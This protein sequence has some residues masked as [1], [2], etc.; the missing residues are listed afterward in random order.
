MFVELFNAGANARSYEPVFLHLVF[1]IVLALSVIFFV[2]NLVVNDGST[3]RSDGHTWWTVSDITTLISAGLVVVQWAAG[4]WTIMTGWRCAFMLLD[5]PGMRVKDLGHV[6]SSSFLVLFDWCL[7]WKP[8][9]SGWKVFTI[10]LLW[11]LI[12]ASVSGPLISGAV[13]WQSTFTWVDGGFVTPSYGGP[14]A[15]TDWYWYLEPMWQLNNDIPDHRPTS[16]A[17]GLAG[18]A[19]STKQQP[20]VGRC[21]RVMPDSSIPPNSTVANATIPCIEIHDISFNSNPSPDI[22]NVLNS[23][24]ENVSLFQN[25]VV[26]PLF[27]YNFGNAILFDSSRWNESYL[28]SGGGT[29]QLPPPTI[30]SGLKTFIVF[31]ARQNAPNCK[32]ING[33]AFGD[34]ATLALLEP[35]LYV[36]QP[37]TS[38]TT[39]CMLIGSVNFTAGVVQSPKSVYVSNRVVETTET[40][41]IEPAMFVKDALL[42]MPDVM[43][44]V[45]QVNTSG[46][47]TWDNVANYTDTLIRYSYMA[48][49][50]SLNSY[51]GPE[52]PD[53]AV[54]KAVPML[55]ASVSRLRVYLWLL[56]N[57]F[58]TVTAIMTVIAYMND[59]IKRMVVDYAAVAMAAKIK[60]VPKGPSQ[61]SQLTSLEAGKSEGSKIT[62]AEVEKDLKILEFVEEEIENEIIQMTELGK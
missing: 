7:P 39:N 46:M 40:L 14:T 61:D 3:R 57:L 31:V 21:R 55:R 54:Q 35:Y 25:N 49:W 10:L 1:T 30:F 12:P 29:P 23:A 6:T 18:L 52:T 41:P 62:Q 56:G 37:F 20:D 51:F 33:S 43:P 34:A 15:L 38:D 42:M 47:A 58:L 45:S 19:W 11:L 60:V 48:S 24:G 9:P 36:W 44:L 22:I 4:T 59:Q 2:D 13:N 8:R 27:T 50:D 17:A 26:G 28:I 32:S 5:G 16:T 53:L